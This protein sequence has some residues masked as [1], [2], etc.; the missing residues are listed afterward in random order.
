[1]WAMMPMLRT[2]FRSVSTSRATR[3]FPCSQAWG[4]A[5][6]AQRRAAMPNY[7]PAVVREG[8][9]GLGH[10]VRVLATLH[11]GTEAVR[12]VEEFVLQALDHRLLAAGLREGD[13]PAQRQ[14]GGATRLDLDRHLVGGA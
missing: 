4:P 8:P 11:R 13:Q 12:S 3:V 10:L 5:W 7:L 6:L 14:G 2:L 9:V 1:M